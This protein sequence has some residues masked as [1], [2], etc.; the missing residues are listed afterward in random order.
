MKNLLYL[1]FLSC[2]LISCSNDDSNS[3]TTSAIQKVVFYKNS[4]NERHWN[5]TNGVLTSIT[6]ADG[7]LAEKFIYDSQNRLIQDIKYNN[8]SVAETDVIT[9]NANNT[10]ASINGLPYTFDSATKTYTY[11]YG[12]NFTINCK[13]NSDFLAVNYTRTG[14][15]AGEYHMTY[16]NGDMT[17]YESVSTGFHKNF[18]FDSS[19]GSNPIHDAVLAVGRV[20]SL[21]DPEFFVDSQVS[22]NMAN[23]FDKGSTDSNYYNY[24]AT[25]SVHKLLE[26][27]VEI[28]DSN[29]NFVGLYSFADYYYE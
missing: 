10:I 18:H 3:N 6:L 14:T 21:T 2:T 23:G 15:N 19:L 29:N 11:V 24:G 25:G 20:K 28:L 13:V 9:Y 16:L 1:F 27:S 17:A 7:S 4:A 8:G 22:Q 5:I 26:I 12:S